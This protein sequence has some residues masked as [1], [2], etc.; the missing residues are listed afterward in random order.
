VTTL[1]SGDLLPWLT[2]LLLGVAIVIV[3]YAVWRDYRRQPGRPIAVD[4]DHNHHGLIWFLL[5]LMLL[6][7]CGPGIRQGAQGPPG[8]QGPAGPPGPSGKPAAT[9]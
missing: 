4:H 5:I 2:L 1:N 9:P 7:I 6:G 3:A 8:P